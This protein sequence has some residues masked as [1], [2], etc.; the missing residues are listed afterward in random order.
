MKK[1]KINFVIKKARALFSYIITFL[2][3]NQAKI[4]F[5]VLLA[6]WTN[7]TL[8]FFYPQYINI[9]YSMYLRL[10]IFGIISMVFYFIKEKP[11]LREIMADSAAIDT[12][13]YQKNTYVVRF[14]RRYQFFIFFL[15]FIAYQGS[16]Y[17]LDSNLLVSNFFGFFSIVLAVG[18]GTQSVYYISSVYSH[19]LMER[20]GRRFFSIGLGGKKVALLC[21]ECAK[22]TIQLGFGLEAAYKLTH[23]GFND[24]SPPRQ[25]L[26]NKFVFPDK[27]DRVWTETSL[28]FEVQKRSN[29]SIN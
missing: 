14:L 2:K 4:L 1:I 15:T 29:E 7:V 10:F 3:K 26:I 6:T 25:Y 23:G 11:F 18:Y 9:L 20:P 17:F 13:F 8:F 5:T 19:K 21:S 12:Q 22:T 27:P 16:A 24:I 28:G